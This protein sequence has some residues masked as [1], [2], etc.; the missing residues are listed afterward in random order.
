ML[1]AHYGKIWVRPIKL[2]LFL[3][4]SRGRIAGTLNRVISFVGEEERPHPNQERQL[5]QALELG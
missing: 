3:Q 5:M 2:H 4:S 1:L